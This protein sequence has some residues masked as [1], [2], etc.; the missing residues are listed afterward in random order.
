MERLYKNYKINDEYE[1]YLTLVDENYLKI[2]IE[3]NLNKYPRK[4]YS[5]YFTYKNLI[6]YLSFLNQ[7]NNL[8][9]IFNGLD[10]IFNKKNY[11]IEFDYF[12]F[13]KLNLLNK[14]FLIISEIDV[15]H[16]KMI[17]K[18]FEKNKELN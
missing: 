12:C 4:F 6:K 15:N 1:L 7:Y 16:T 14:S 5:K 2:S 13:I 10:D 3:N 17:K 9:E 18:L 11:N 8:Y